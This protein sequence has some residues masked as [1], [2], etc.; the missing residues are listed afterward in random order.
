METVKRLRLFE[1]VI[2]AIKKMIVNDGFLPGDK[3][4]SEKMLT[5]K[6]MVSRSS[7]REA[8]RMLEVT[9]Q[10]IVRH[11]K[12]IYIADSLEK[13]FEG[14]TEWLK[15]NETSIHDH[16]EVRM[17][18]DPK[19]AAYA[20][21]KADPDDIKKMEELCA[22]FDLNSSLKNKAGLIKCDEEFHLLLAKSTKNKSLY[23]LM[24]TMTKSL[25]E[26]W[27]SSLNIP[28]RIDKTISEHK[29]I[30]DAI[31]NKDTERA[32]KEMKNHLERALEDILGS[33]KQ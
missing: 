20:A 25:P 15:N 24:K 30:L 32:E 26:G 5:E 14:F 8:V 3:F 2:E 23:F 9:G 28:G 33:I 17:I 19:A 16:F 7:V 11:G 4:Y 22:D 27:I 6:L 21:E 12:G 10:V 31:K 29:M 1:S 18:L 13:E